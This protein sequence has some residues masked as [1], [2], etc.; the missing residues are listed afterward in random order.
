MSK[1]FGSVR[2]DILADIEAIRLG[3]IPAATGT[4][5]AALYKE[6]NS[7]MMVEIHAAKVALAT[8]GRAREFGKVVKLGLRVVNDST[9]EA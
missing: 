4:V 3:K 2:T 6:L 8:E 7:N 9:P 1:T 5:M